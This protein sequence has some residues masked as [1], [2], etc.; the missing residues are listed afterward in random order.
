LE[1]HLREGT[2]NE[3]MKKLLDWVRAKREYFSRSIETGF[4]DRIKIAG[5][6]P[7]NSKGGEN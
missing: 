2:F 5:H 7:A 3:K 4:E 1:K 6:S